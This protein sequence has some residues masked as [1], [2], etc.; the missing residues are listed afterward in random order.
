MQYKTPDLLHDGL[1]RLRRDRGDFGWTLVIVGC[2]THAPRNVYLVKECNH[3]FSRSTL[4]LSCTPAL[5]T[6]QQVMGPLNAMQ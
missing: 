3:R 1:Y 6:S 4:C 5:H 2:I